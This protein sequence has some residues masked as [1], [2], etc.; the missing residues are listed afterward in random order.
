MPGHWQAVPEITPQGVVRSKLM[1]NLLIL[2]CRFQAPDVLARKQAG[3][4]RRK[5]AGDLRC[6]AFQQGAI[7]NVGGDDGG[8]TGSQAVIQQAVKVVM[9]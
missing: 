6:I 8:Q 4:Q 7:R 5:T 9:K 3:G 2:L 1:G